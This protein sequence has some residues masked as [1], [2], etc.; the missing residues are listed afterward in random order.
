MTPGSV[1]FSD[2][3]FLFVGEFPISVASHW[4]E[5]RNFW[6]ETGKQETG[7]INEL[8]SWQIFGSLVQNLKR[9]RSSRSRKRNRR[10][11]GG[12]NELVSLSKQINPIQII[13]LS[14]YV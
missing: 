7:V 12:I 5:N 8:C 11:R 14:N 9:S 4:S 2:L 3:F 10:R 6:P 13:P 1:S